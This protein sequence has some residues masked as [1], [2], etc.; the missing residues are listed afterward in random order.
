MGERYLNEMADLKRAFDPKNI[1]GE[2]EYV[3]LE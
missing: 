2:R 3:W 1:L